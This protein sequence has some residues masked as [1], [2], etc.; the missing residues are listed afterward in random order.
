[1]ATLRQCL[2]MQWTMS[3]PHWKIWECL[4]GS[5]SPKP[6]S[7]HGHR[8]LSMSYI[9]HPRK[10]RSQDRLLR[11]GWGQEE[12]TIRIKKATAAITIYQTGTM[13]VRRS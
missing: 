6:L 2:D 10:G 1:M 9:N 13:M 3:C 4:E 12:V 5:R 11:L 8:K 7:T